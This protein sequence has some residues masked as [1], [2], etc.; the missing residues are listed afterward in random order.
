MGSLLVQQIMHG[1]GYSMCIDAQVWEVQPHLF[2]PEIFAS[3]C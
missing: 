2:M 1:F 3:A